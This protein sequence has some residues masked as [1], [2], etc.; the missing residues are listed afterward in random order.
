ML[1][2]VKVFNYTKNDAEVCARNFLKRFSLDNDRHKYP[3]QLSGGQ[4]QRIG[5]ARAVAIK[6]LLLLLDEPTS[7]LD[8]ELTGEVLDMIQELKSEKLNI[9]LVTH[10]MGF[11]R[12]SCDQVVFMSDGHIIESGEG[13]ILFS[14]PKSPE[15][16]TFLSKVLEW[17]I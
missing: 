3:Y 5:I 13:K 16:R 1:P 2:L 6:P 8:P 15:L 17:K 11:A 9:I 7:A 14:N 12:N 10:E 4:C